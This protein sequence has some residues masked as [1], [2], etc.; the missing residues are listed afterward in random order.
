MCDLVLSQM[1]QHTH[2]AKSYYPNSQLYI[3]QCLFWFIL[4]PAI[5][6]KVNNIEHNSFVNL[7]I[8]N[9]VYVFLNYVIH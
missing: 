1:T 2:G 4:E 9:N 8:Y 6:E 5:D 7:Q 3:I